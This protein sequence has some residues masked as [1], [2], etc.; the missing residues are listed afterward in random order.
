MEILTAEQ[1]RFLESQ[2]SAAMI[3][4]GPGGVPRAVRV[5][6]ALVDGKLWSSGDTPALRS[7]GQYL[8]E[9]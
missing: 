5:A 4:I 3:T 7:L 6:I 1:R 8:Q 2:H 9:R